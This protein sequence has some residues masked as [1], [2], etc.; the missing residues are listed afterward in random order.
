MVNTIQTPHCTTVIQHNKTPCSLIAAM[1]QQFNV[2]IFLSVD[3][4]SLQARW[5]LIRVSENRGCSESKRSASLLLFNPVFIATAMPRISNTVD[6]VMAPESSNLKQR[7]A[8]D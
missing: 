3:L 2:H 1:S 6:Q 5:L 7:K 8:L 4:V